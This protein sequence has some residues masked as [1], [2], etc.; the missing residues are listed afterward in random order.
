MASEGQLGR[1]DVEGL[2]RI[3]LVVFLLFGAR[4]QSAKQV[5]MGSFLQ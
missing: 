3:R 5:W 4:T 1:M 2:C